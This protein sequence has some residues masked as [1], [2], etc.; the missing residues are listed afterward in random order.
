MLETDI[1]KKK[2]DEG[3]GNLDFIYW[4]VV[5][6]SQRHSNFKT[7]LITIIPTEVAK[8]AK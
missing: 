2:K 3:K 8:Y 1:W 7:I 6:I 4:H 5:P